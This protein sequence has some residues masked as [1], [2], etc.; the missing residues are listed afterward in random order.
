MATTTPQPPSPSST[1]PV[2]GIVEER[3]RC[4]EDGTFTI[5]QFN[6]TQDSH[7][8]DARTIALQEAVLDDV[9]PDLVVLNGDVID[10]S[11]TTA[12]E[13]KQAI[14]N[15]V[16]P[17]EERGI[18]W[19]LTFGNH[20]EDSTAVT[21]MDEA[22]Y[23]EFVAQYP[24]NLNTAGA[25]G[26]SGSGNQVLTVSSSRGDRAVYAVWLL[27]SGR[28]APEQIAGQDLAGHPRW[29]WVRPDQIRWYLTASEEL[30]H[31]A[32]HRV[33]GLL[34]Q[35][36]PLWEHRCAWFG[37]A[38]S[39]TDEDHARARVRHRIVGERNEVES[40]GPFNSGLFTALLHRGDV[41]GLFV[42]HDHTN[43]YA[44]DYYGI[45]L[46]YGPGT[47]FGAYGLE[48]AEEHRLRGARVF[49]LDEQAESVWIGTELRFAADYGIDLRPGTQPGE[50]APLPGGV[51]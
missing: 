13:A 12:L 48:G 37:S 4:R 50:P 14:N 44:A 24:H 20:D 9:R 1:A 47:G 2:T 8:T 35:H 16:V 42:G 46:G 11:P 32:G 21:G 23:L 6:D 36:I 18:P 49:R 41:Q 45:T 30:Q 31:R 34:F 26:I 25:E 15:V 38:D 10:G 40:P 39:R 7:R 29:D 17:M 33:S 43:T 5:V 3:L 28:Y 51:R 19:A 27:D 22:A